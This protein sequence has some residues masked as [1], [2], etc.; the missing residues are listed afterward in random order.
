MDRMGDEHHRQVLLLP[1]TQQIAIELIARNFI[2]RAEGGSSISSSFGRVTRPRA[3]ETRICMPP[4]SSRGRTLANLPS[5]TSSRASLTRGVG[6]CSWDAGKIQGQPDVAMDAA[7]GHQRG[8]LED[9][10]EGKLGF[11][12]LSRRHSISLP[13]S[14]FHQTGDHLQQVLFPQP[15]GPSRV[16]N[17]P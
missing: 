1:E 11:F 17:S 14:G 4:E 12:P 6:F 10:R 15:E 7:P 16:T 2:Q 13:S 8:F 3:M 5:P 9:E